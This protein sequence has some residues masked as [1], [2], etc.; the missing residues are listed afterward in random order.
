MNRRQEHNWQTPLLGKIAEFIASG[1][2]S[3]QRLCGL[4]F[5]LARLH[6]QRIPIYRKLCEMRGVDLDRVQR[7]ED[8]PAVSSDAF[9]RAELHIKPGAVVHRFTS[10]GTS[11]GENKK[12]IACFSGD[13]FSLMD[14]AV[15]VNAERFLFP[16]HA[17][18]KTLILILA[19][20]PDIAPQ[21]IMVYGMKRLRD[22]Y[23]MEGSDFLIGPQ[24]LDFPRL[25]NSLAEAC[26]NGIPVTII[27]ASFGFI[28]LFSA[29]SERN[30]RFQLPKFSRCMDAGG[31]K[32]K[33]REVRRDEMIE[34]FEKHLGIAAGYCVN[35]LGLTEHASQFYDGAL[36]AA[37]TKSPPLKG[38]RNTPWTRTWAVNPETLA[39]LPHGETGILRHLDLANGGHPFLVQTDDLGFTYENGFEVIGRASNAESRG[40]SLTVDELVASGE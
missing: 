7:L 16:D 8:L 18:R 4:A 15:D 2:E 35:L 5:E 40:C 27:G 14:V 13:D 19:P 9:K 1:S 10:S 31:F 17:E 28:H 32:G 23:G 21:M 37:Y 12:G 11:G 25:V 20:S 22:N 38:K 30:L 36:A 3:E 39:V 34:A 24:G 26:A 33:S 6:H 29:L